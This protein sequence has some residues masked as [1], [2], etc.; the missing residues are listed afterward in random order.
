MKNW[1]SALCNRPALSP[2]KEKQL[3]AFLR[4][5]AGRHCM[6]EPRLVSRTADYINREQPAMKKAILADARKTCGLK[7]NLFA[8]DFDLGRI[9]RERGRKGQCGLIPWFHELKRGTTFYPDPVTHVV[10]PE[11]SEKGCSGKYMNDLSRY[12]WVTSLG[13]AYALTGD[14]RYARMFVAITEDFFAYAPPPGGAPWSDAMSIGIRAVNLVALWAFFQKS[15]SLTDRF[16]IRFWQSLVEHLR[17]CMQEAQDWPIEPPHP[18]AEMPHIKKVRRQ[19]KVFRLRTNHYLGGRIGVWAILCA[20]PDSQDVKRMRSVVRADFE[21]EIIAETVE[22]G[23]NFEASTQYH[24]LVNEMFFCWA[25]T[26]RNSGVAI[27]KKALTRF[28][29]QFAFTRDITKPDGLVP[30]VGDMDNGRVHIYGYGDWRD[31][32]YLTQLGGCFFKDRSLWAPGTKLDRYALWH[33]GPIA[34]RYTDDRKIPRQQ[35]AVFGTTGVAV[36]RNGDAYAAMFA[37]KNRQA[38]A[39][40]HSHEDKLEVEYSLGH[41]N[42]LVDP[43]QGT[44][45]GEWGKRVRMRSA[46][47]HSVLTVDDKDINPIT[48]GYPWF[49]PDNANAGLIKAD[50]AKRLAVGEHRGF[51]ACGMKRYQRTM[52]LHDCGGLTV[53]D[54]VP[55]SGTHKLTWR[56][57][58]GPEMKARVNKAGDVVSIADK[59][60]VCA[61][62][63]VR[64]GFRASIKVL[65]GLYAPEYGRDIP[66]RIITITAR[67]RLPATATFTVVPVND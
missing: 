32:R 31:H 46:C 26:C 62:F 18:M 40:G 55:G 17:V 57:V 37:L 48:P 61:R 63:R 10:K 16:V 20:L 39:G 38:G 25:M 28:R 36:F 6:I 59:D 67:V 64:A 50:T 4:R 27:S 35:S 29:K 65:P 43:G 34:A 13:E 12:Q 45:G 3:A 23:M 51:P 42:I 1:W 5:K 19:G 41:K 30:Q 14:E 7:V 53:T 2:A 11:G 15:K 24:R 33:F 9:V 44:Y 8:D 47:S 54:K 60:G 66:T 58:L 49:V 56:F 22:D 21:R 52:Q